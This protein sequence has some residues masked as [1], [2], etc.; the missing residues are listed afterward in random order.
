M[1][2]FT[3]FHVLCVALTL[4]VN[5]ATAQ[6]VAIPDPNLEQLVR[7]TLQLPS[8]VQI[9]R[10]HMGTL[11][12]QNTTRPLTQLGGVADRGI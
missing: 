2:R 5:V 1:T 4:L 3:R 6:V 9:E 10:G 11:M 7:E 12:L 8:D